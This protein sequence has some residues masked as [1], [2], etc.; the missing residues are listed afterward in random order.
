[1]SSISSCLSRFPGPRLSSNGL[2]IPNDLGEAEVLCSP[3]RAS[4]PAPWPFSCDSLP[5]TPGARSG[6]ECPSETTPRRQQLLKSQRPRRTYLG[7]EEANNSGRQTRETPRV[8]SQ[9]L[10]EESTV[11]ALKVQGRIFREVNNSV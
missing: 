5:R 1:M 4:T 3:S 11:T 9:Q 7:F 6:L 10:L 8:A 2:N